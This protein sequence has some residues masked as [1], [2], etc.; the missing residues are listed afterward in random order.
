M[1]LIDFV[2]TRICDQ[3]GRPVKLTPRWSVEE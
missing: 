1:D 2:V 3:L